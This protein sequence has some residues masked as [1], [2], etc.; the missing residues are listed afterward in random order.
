MDKAPALI[1]GSGIWIAVD[2]EKWLLLVAYSRETE[3]SSP[4]ET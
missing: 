4:S 3:T 2:M 1:R